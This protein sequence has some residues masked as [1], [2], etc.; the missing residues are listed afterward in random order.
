[1]PVVGEASVCV[2]GEGAGG[3]SGVVRVQGCAS[4]RGALAG[5]AQALALGGVWADGIILAISPK[6]L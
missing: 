1:M 2:D 4:H 6:L 3:A 5:V